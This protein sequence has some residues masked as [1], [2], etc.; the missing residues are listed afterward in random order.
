MLS[1]V[2]LAFPAGLIDNPIMPRH[3]PDDDDYEDDIAAGDDDDDALT[4]CPHCGRP[5]YEG[6]ERCPKCGQYLSV[7][8]APPS[9]KP[10]WIVVGTLLCLYA[11]YRWVA[12]G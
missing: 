11:V 9:R 3:E 12:G 2:T 1:R 7:E 6:S 5:I 10:W 4:E 8:D